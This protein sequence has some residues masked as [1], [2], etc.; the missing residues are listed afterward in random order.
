MDEIKALGT[1]KGEKAT[2]KEDNGD[3]ITR[4]AERAAYLRRKYPLNSPQFSPPPCRGRVRQLHRGQH[5]HA[6]HHHRQRVV[7]TGLPRPRGPLHLHMH[8]CMHKH[9]HIFLHFW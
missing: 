7:C 8:T 5:G 2:W 9:N 3:T 1:Y 4:K 6:E